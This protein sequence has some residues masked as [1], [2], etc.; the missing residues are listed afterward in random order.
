MEFS[1]ADMTFRRIYSS[2]Y[3]L[4][5]TFVVTTWSCVIA[6]FTWLVERLRFLCEL[7]SH[8]TTLCHELTFSGGLQEPTRCLFG[9][10]L[11]FGWTSITFHICLHGSVPFVHLWPIYYDFEM[12]ELSI[13][14]YPVPRAQY[15]NKSHLQSIL[16]T[17]FRL[18]PEAFV[19]Q[20]IPT[21]NDLLH[22]QGQLF[23]P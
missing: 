6:L 16:L 21:R 22:H 18:I 5:L 20:T 8:G 7:S 1:T 11:R 2:L 23:P 14:E 15:L 13:S 10:H 9:N 19:T 3:R 4:A 17:V 12:T